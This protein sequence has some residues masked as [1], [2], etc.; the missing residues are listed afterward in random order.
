MSPGLVP[1]PPVAMQAALAVFFGRLWEAEPCFGLCWR[2][3]V[4]W[5]LGVTQSR[6]RVVGRTVQ[7]R[8]LGRVLPWDPSACL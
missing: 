4:L 1:R 5:G 2:G 3:G 8:A 7:D 6:P